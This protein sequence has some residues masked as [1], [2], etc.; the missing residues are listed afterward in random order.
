M[1]FLLILCLL[2]VETAWRMKVSAD[3]AEVPT[4][5][6]ELGETESQREAFVEGH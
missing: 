4:T 6:M 1:G 3:A 2:N 5:I